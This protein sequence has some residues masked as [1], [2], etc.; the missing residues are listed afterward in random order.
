MQSVLTQAVL[1]VANTYISNLQAGLSLTLWAGDVTLDNLQ[2]RLEA[3]PMPQHLALTKGF[4]GQLSVHIPWASLLY[5]PIKVTLADIQIEVATTNTSRH[6]RPTP[7]PPPAAAVEEKEKEKGGWIQ[8]VMN[9]VLGNVSV[10]IRHLNIVFRDGDI[11]C[12]MHVDSIQLFSCSPSWN[13]AF[14]VRFD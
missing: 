7:P 9:K 3:I 11:A 14:S 5:N 13:Q 2:I 10:E 1:N 6:V 4:I 8:S 12:T